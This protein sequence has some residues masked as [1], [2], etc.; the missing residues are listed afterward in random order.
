MS[1]L[2]LFPPTSVSIWSAWCDGAS[3]GN[4]GPAAYGVVVC[5]PAGA[6]VREIGQTLG[7]DTNQAAEY[8]GLLRALEELI[9]LG[10]R[11]ARIF[12]DSQFVVRQYTGEYKARDERMKSFLDHVRRRA[13][14]LEKLELTHIPRSSHPHNVLADKLANQALDD[15]RHHP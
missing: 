8:E 12:T 9:R 6:V 11:R 13:A 14:S 7:K 1:Q 4:P 10:A 15:A 5:D 3:R 2:P